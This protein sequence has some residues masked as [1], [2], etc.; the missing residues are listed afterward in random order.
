MACNAQT[1]RFMF[2]EYSKPVEPAKGQKKRRGGPSEVRAH[3]TKNYHRTLRVKRLESLKQ[4]E[5][6]ASF[7]SEH[8]LLQRQDSSEGNDDDEYLDSEVINQAPWSM[9]DVNPTISPSAPRPAWTKPSPST[10]ATTT[11]TSWSSEAS[12]RSSTNED[13]PFRLNTSFGLQTVLGQGRFDP[14]DVLPVQGVPMFVHQVLDHALVHSWPNT[15]PVK[16][17][18]APMNPVKSSWLKLAMEHP[19]AFHAFLYAT[20]FHILCAHQGQEIDDSAALLRLSHKV[21]TIKLVN[22]QLQNLSLVPKQKAS[23]SEDEGGNKPP[24]K[25]VGTG[26]GT[27]PTDALIMAVTIL[28][29]H[30]QRD[31]SVYAKVHAQSPL[32]RLNHL[33]IY[34]SMINDEKHIQG[35]RL[36]VGQKGGLDAIECYG[37]ADTMQLCDLYFASKY[38]C[39]PTYAWRK[40]VKSP[41]MGGKHVLDPAAIELDSNLGSGFRYLR[42]TYTGQQLLDVL[43]AYSEITV[44]LDHHVRGGPTAPELVDLMEVRNCTQHRLLSQ[45][46]NPVDLSNSELCLHQAVRLASLIFSDMVIF[47]LPPTQGVKPR[48]ALMLRQTLET[49]HL[50]RSW[51]LHNQVLLWALTLGAIAASYTAQRPWYIGQLLQETSVMQI[52]DCS[53]LVVGANLQRTAALGVERA[54]FTKST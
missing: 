5:V 54:D 27:G 8:K 6:P 53:I 1:G 49:C 50:H 47:P 18:L 26:T 2:V 20:S 14:F 36:L 40:P 43:D 17:S 11:T 15:V 30:S 22:E 41:V 19:V 33:D 48:L 31:E 38:S 21:E 4:G 13:L 12:P 37:M 35:I 25:S 32:A 51:E 45:L 44:A 23:G 29:I 9:G 34:G 28:S 7:G 10:S 16:R 52:E 3:I 46:P 39:R 42:H 24:S